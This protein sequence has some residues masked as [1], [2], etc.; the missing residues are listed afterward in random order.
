MTTLVRASLLIWWAF[1]CFGKVLE[2]QIP[3]EHYPY[4]LELDAAAVRAH[5]LRSLEL[6]NDASDH[7]F[8]ALACEFDQEGLI[9]RQLEYFGSREGKLEVFEHD[10]DG[11][12]TAIL[13]YDMPPYAGQLSVDTTGLGRHSAFKFEYGDFGK[14]SFWRNAV[15]KWKLGEEEKYLRILNG[16]PSR[17]EY[18]KRGKLIGVVLEIEE[19]ERMPVFPKGIPFKINVVNKRGQVTRQIERVEIESMAPLDSEEAY[20]PSYETYFRNWTYRNDLAVSY[21]DSAYFGERFDRHYGW[22][23]LYD[24]QGRLLE[25]HVRYDDDGTFVK[26]VFKYE[27]L[28]TISVRT[29]DAS[30]VARYKETEILL[31]EGGLPA[32]RIEK[33]GNSG[34]GIYSRIIRTEFKYAFWE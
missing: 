19:G 30:S 14:Q 22:S 20:S 29:S 6:V 2:A 13:T 5:G 8:H 15:G 31:N 7:R 24:A 33:V 34:P 17:V 18:L 12:P 9:V 3:E 28:R 4:P 11:R 27:D 25:K 10:K 21:S 1:F 16:R 23:Q 32:E 26:E